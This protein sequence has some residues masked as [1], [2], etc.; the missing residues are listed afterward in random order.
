MIV[1]VDTSVW[2]LA[3]RR[4]RGA[5]PP[6]AAALAPRVRHGRVAIIG[7]H[8]ELA[9]RCFNQCRAPTRRDARRLDVFSAQAWTSSPW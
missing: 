5:T 4:S 8:F 2:C 6:E 7:D 1:L 3:L 9:A